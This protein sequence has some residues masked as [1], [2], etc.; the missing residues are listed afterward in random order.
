[1]AQ[2]FTEQFLRDMAEFNERPV[3]F[4][5]SNPTDLAECTAE[6]A[7]KFTDVRSGDVG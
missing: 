6:D 2:V 1:M 3:I 5:L 7:Y 4:A